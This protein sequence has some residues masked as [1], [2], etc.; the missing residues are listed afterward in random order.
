MVLTGADVGAKGGEF[1]RQAYT[2]GGVFDNLGVRMFRC[3]AASNPEQPAWDGVL[4]S[5][6]GRPFEVRNA[7]RA[8]GMIRTAM[9]ASDILMDR[10]WQLE[11]ETFK[12][13]AGFAF[14]R[15]TAVV[16]QAEDP[17]ALHP[18]VQRQLPNIRT[19]LDRFSDDEISALVRHGYCVGRKTCRAFPK[20][21]GKKLTTR[22]AW[23]PNGED[24]DR[25]IAAAAP[26]TALVQVTDPAKLALPKQ[27]STSPPL[28]LWHALVSHDNRAVRALK[29]FVS[30]E[31]AV[32]FPTRAPI[33]AT[34]EARTLHG[35]ASRRIWSTLLDHRD[36]V[37]YVYVPIIV[38]IL[39]LTPYLAYKVYERS[40]RINQIVESLSQQSRDLEQMTR[41][42]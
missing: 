1:G 17:S 40:H 30:R 25:L 38:P 36:W 35:S 19:D 4:V 31:T 23:D 16:D 13:T 7:R 28:Q 42:M 29:S 33:E 22:P 12:D 37:S 10:V 6:A 34:L 18:E 20:L 11:T 3:L 27:H 15:I 14:A 41:L 21:F 26:R 32:T 2:D 8:G 9:R 24:E 5:D 39:F